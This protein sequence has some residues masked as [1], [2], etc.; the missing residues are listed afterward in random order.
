MEGTIPNRIE[1]ELERLAGAP[2]GRIGAPLHAV[3]LLTR[4]AGGLEPL[5][6]DAL[7]VRRHRAA[8][9]AVAATALATAA[10]VHG[11]FGDRP[12]PA[13]SRA[14]AMTALRER[15]RVGPG[16][17]AGGI[18]RALGEVARVV[19]AL[20]PVD[21]GGLDWELGAIAFADEDALRALYDACLALAVVAVR[22]AAGA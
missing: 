3:A 5:A 11:A 6:N 18:I 8:A 13:R 15:T 2:G 21:D 10:S 19:L 22:E 4:A 14:R 17:E 12:E 9:R 7:G 16:P 20:P 1:T